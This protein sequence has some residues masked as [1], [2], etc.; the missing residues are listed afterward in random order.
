LSFSTEANPATSDTLVYSYAVIIAGTFWF[1]VVALMYMMVGIT[2]DAKEDND[3]D[4]EL[5]PLSL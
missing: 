4:E 1:L 5:A 3:D 2:P